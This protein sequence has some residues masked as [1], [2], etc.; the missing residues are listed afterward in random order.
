[1]AADFSV[2]SDSAQ[3]NTAL[4]STKVRLVDDPT[5]AEQEERRVRL[6]AWVADHWGHAK[7]T[8]QFHLTASQASFLSQVTNGYSFASRAARNMERR[9]RMPVRWLDGTVVTA[10]PGAAVASGASTTIT[11][12]TAPTL[13]EAL[14]V[15]LAALRDLPPTSTPA[16]T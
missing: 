7:V 5:D 9:L 3:V 12:P 15:A 4:V 1:M 6:R 8:E 16:R 2:Y 11:A 14:R 10:R 13:E